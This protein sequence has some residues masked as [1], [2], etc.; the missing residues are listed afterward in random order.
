MKAEPLTARGRRTRD[1]LLEAGRQVLESR[2]YN[3]TTADD[4]AD[5]AGVSHG[6]FY[7]WFTDKDALMR[8]L[9]DTTLTDARLAFHVPETITDPVE[10]I[11]EAN[12]RYLTTFANYARM[13]EVVEEVATV[14][15]YYRDL[16]IG[17]RREYV[18]RITTTIARLQA[19][20]LV[21]IT[22]NAHVAASALSAMVEGFA[23]HWLGRGEEHDAEIAVHTLSLLWARA[24]GLSVHQ[25]QEVSDV[26]AH[27]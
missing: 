12:R 1:A 5:A 16:L 21:D 10:R 14:D 22:L 7:T 24:L 26:A 11:T 15:P 18:G 17:L 9:V 4:I 19:N 3:A 20:G 25:S 27:V 13:Y 23:R 6:T 2:G 8:A